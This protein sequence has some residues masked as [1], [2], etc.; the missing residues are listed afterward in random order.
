MKRSKR[1]AS[2]G[3]HKAVI[4]DFDGTLADSFEYVF[5]FLKAEAGNDKTYTKTELQALHGMSMKRLAVRLGI[6]AWRLLPVYF[7][8]RR[9]M[10]AH[11]EHVQL[12]SGM[13]AVLNQLHEQGCWLFVVS[14]N[15]SGN[16]RRA[17]KRHGVDPYFKAIRGSAGLTGKAAILR[18]LSLQ[19][20]LP[21][22]TTWYVGDETAD[23]VSAA[24]AGLRSLAV[25][26]G[27]ADPA[28]LREVGPDALANTPADIPKLLEAAWKK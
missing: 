19:Y 11:M 24:R 13:T 1:A 7:K 5:E 6:P 16:I 15:S 4:F 9:V 2:T 3:R 10:R 18:Q 28:H 25:G 27:F 23:I 20:R 21:A 8:G 14:S 22:R 12:F 17:L 26:W